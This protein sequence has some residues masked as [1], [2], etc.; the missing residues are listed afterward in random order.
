MA[1]GSRRTKLSGSLPPS[2][3][4]VVDNGSYTLKAGFSSPSS[5]LTET[6][7]SASTPSIIP[8]CLARDREKNVYI[9][10]QLSSCKDFGDIVFRRPMEKGYIVNWEAE[11][12]IWEHEFFDAKAK[13]HCDPKETGLILT[14][15]PNA[16]PVLQGH[17]D[18]MVFEEFG[19]ARYLRTNGATLNAYNDIQSSFKAPAPA[20]EIV[21]TPPAEILMLI[22]SSYSHTTITPLLLGRPLQKSVRRLEVGG[23]LLTNYLTRLIN[24]RQ[25]DMKEET[26]LVNEIKEATL[27]VSNDFRK[28]MER[29][30][31]GPKGD[32]RPV[33]ESGEGIAKDYVLPDYHAKK[34][35]FVRDHDPTAATKLKE[36]TKGKSL[37]ASEDVLT[38]RNERFTVPE[39]LFNPSDIGLRQSGI[40]QQVM[41]SLSSIPMGLWPGF[42][43]NIFVV[44]G[45]SNI[46]GFVPRLQTEIRALAP[47]EC[48]VR[49]AK[50]ADPVTSTWQ[51][52]A[53]LAKN[54]E[55]LRNLSVTKEEYE[56]YG[57]AWVARR[58]G[59]R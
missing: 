21:S 51:G 26:Y 9:G 4:L 46:H 59:G 20:A 58:F 44:G 22:D 41:D 53:N 39:L 32:R 57:G 8:N 2:R 45:N 25:Y 6:S 23:K 14:E 49:V 30:W 31:K 55:A 5:L 43:A 50:P 35:G 1:P 48:I 38:L 27:Y 29:T 56:E 19:F 24:V 13:L 11:K 40:A 52:G 47:A 28:D 16:L 7:T 17:C 18:Q 15:A 54:E 10:S 37:G 3:T 36:L 33:F 42:L 34:A 12:E